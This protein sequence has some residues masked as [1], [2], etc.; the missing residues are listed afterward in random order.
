AITETYIP[1]LQMM[2]RLVND[3]CPSRSRCRSRQRSA[4]CLEDE[5]LRG[6]YVRHLDLLIDLVARERKRNRN[7]PELRELAEFYSDIFSES[8]CFFLDEWKCDL[9]S[10]FREVRETGALEII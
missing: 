2:Q 5:L 6:R 9:L 7:Q 3:T 8:R 10:G 1:L 4:R